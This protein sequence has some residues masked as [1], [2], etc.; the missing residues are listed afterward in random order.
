ML[1]PGLK[2]GS[3]DFGCGDTFFDVMTPLLL[4]GS[5]KPKSLHVFILTKRRSWKTMSHQKWVILSLTWSIK[6]PFCRILMAEN[7]GAYWN[8]PTKIWYF[9]PLQS[10][11]SLTSFLYLCRSLK[12]CSWR[13]N[14]TDHCGWNAW[15]SKEAPS[16][17]MT[18]LEVTS[19]VPSA[20]SSCVPPL[21]CLATTTTA[22]NA[23]RVC[24]K[25]GVVSAP[26]V[27]LGWKKTTTPRSTRNW[28]TTWMHFLIISK[29]RCT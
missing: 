3:L 6:C 29:I 1:P 12:R 17:G 25:Q 16:L 14:P 20:T 21:P 24:S 18:M 11:V 5:L 9:W 19:L 2:Q 23:S 8:T 4:H 28:K 7:S 15:T 27:G 26:V 13:T 22:L 10:V